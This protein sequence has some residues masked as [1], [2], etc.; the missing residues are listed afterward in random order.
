MDIVER[1]TYLCMVTQAELMTDLKREYS[2][3]WWIRTVTSSTSRTAHSPCW[4]QR[5]PQRESSCGRRWVLRTPSLSKPASV[6]RI[7]ENSLTT[8]LIQI[9]SKKSAIV[10]ATRYWT[11]VIP[12][13]SRWSKYSKNLKSCCPKHLTPNQRMKASE[14]VMIWK[15]MQTPRVLKPASK[16]K[17]S[18]QKERR[19]AKI[20]RVLRIRIAQHKM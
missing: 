18:L 11:S 3:A 12:T 4:K 16:R 14:T 9:F 8:T 2:H 20:S 10:S 6:G 17:L 7:K 1:R 15:T 5:N 19:E 13:K